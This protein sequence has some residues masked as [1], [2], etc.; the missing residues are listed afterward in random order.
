MGDRKDIKVEGD[1]L[2]FHP[3]FFWVRLWYYPVEG[4]KKLSDIAKSLKE[5][6]EKFQKN[7]LGL[8]L[9]DIQIEWLYIMKNLIP[10]IYLVQ[11]Q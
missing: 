5:I 6:S 8:G 1:S 10:G 11:E 7:W 4:V 9:M 3:K 2:F